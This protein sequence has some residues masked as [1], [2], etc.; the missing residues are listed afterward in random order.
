M[1][2]FWCRQLLGRP[3]AA[4]RFRPHVEALDGRI[5]PTFLP[6]A[7]FAVAG[8]T[9]AVKSADFT[10]DG[11]ADLAVLSSS[12]VAFQ[13]VGTLT[14]LPG[15]GDGTFGAP[16]SS[17]A[18][19]NP[20]SLTIGDDNR[21]GLKDVVVSGYGAVY[22][23][24][25]KGDGSFQPAAYYPV[26]ASP[27]EVT[28]GDLNGDGYPDLVTASPG[29]GGTATVIPN[30]GDGTYAPGHNEATSVGM[31]DV[32]LEDLNHDGK[33]DIV[34]G[35]AGGV[36]VKLGNGDGTFQSQRVFA[37]AGTRRLVVADFNHDGNAD[38]VALAG[39]IFGQGT[40]MPV[41]LGL[42]DGTFQP[43]SAF[44]LSSIPTDVVAA[45]FNADGNLDLVEPMASGYQV[46][47]GRGDGTFYAP[48]GVAGGPGGRAGV[49]D[50]NGDGMADVVSASSALVGGLSTGQVAELV[51]ANDWATMCGATGL[52]V[53]APATAV[54]GQ[55]FSVTVTA[56]DAA[57]NPAPNFQGS[58]ALTLGTGRG[59]QPVS[60]T[61]AAA[62]AGVHTFIGAASLLAAGPQAVVATSP[63]ILN[64]TA[65][66]QVT[67]AA[68][69]R[70]VVGTPL[71]AAA[72][73]SVVV[74]VSALDPYGNVSPGYAGTVRFA[75]SDP[76]AT[77]PATYAFSAADAGVHTFAVSFRSTGAQALTATD[78]LAPA[79][80]GNSPVVNVTPGVAV[81]L[82]VSGGGGFVGS[83]H[84]VTVTARDMFGNI[85]TGY[86]G[87]AH[88]AGSDPATF[89]PADL[90]MTNG[91]AVFS[92]TPMT[93]GSL[94]LTATTASGLNASQTVTVTPG[95]AARLVVT[96]LA[97]GVA[98]TAQPMTVTAYD[99]FGNLSTVYT[100]TVLVGGTDP[101]AA[102]AY[103]FTAADAGVHTFSVALKTAGTQ[104]VTVRDSADATVSATQAGV[105]V[106]PAAAV[107]LN[108]TLLSNAVA[109]TVQTMT[110]CLR[111][112]YGNAATGY[113]GTLHFGS[114]DVLAGLP[115]DTTFT[116]ADAGTKTFTVTL[117]S[118]RGQIVTVGDT[119]NAALAFSQTDIQVSAAAMVGFAFR[120]PSSATAGVAFTV[121]L[122]A[123][124][125]FGNVITGYTGRVHFSGPGGIPADTTF[126]TADA[127]A[128]TF[129]LTL[130][131]T[132]TQTVSVAD[133][134]AGGLR[135]S[136]AISV[137]A[138]GGGG[139][140][141]KP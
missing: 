56:V 128:K 109:G 50:F 136:F 54:A 8:T 106:T 83:A 3:P 21:D 26:G 104:S 127:G 139:G 105:V 15:N 74:S 114:T 55:L 94:T 16:I 20:T 117:K 78:T 13:T 2:R 41:L 76:L 48:V 10:G 97:G 119:A 75:S 52:Q 115:A 140:G 37:A 95:W 141:K 18:G 46:E 123:V 53:V 134:L 90:T 93:L 82:A 86:T 81:S 124:D 137:K 57:G 4:R 91:T 111:D 17:P 59:A 47:L 107:A 84:P 80:T 131:A 63:F 126:T 135:G 101:Q 34:S 43:A 130:T 32:K 77:L 36:G 38:V 64:G 1:F 102:Q 39:T 118:A 40:S 24:H 108:S 5:V 51:N 35:S 138:A 58:V 132:G 92:V 99:A 12:V 49:G 69:T 73:E 22:V 96:P 125:A 14:V 9:V 7:G 65:S 31:L 61:F 89:M 30:N 72:G 44:F 66:V 120:A 33:L 98:G 129:S 6:A 23:L 71:G 87:T 67:P 133:T 112:A 70:L 85:A 103:A 25:G 116:A 79:L 42:G 45:D 62:D 122:S 110:V 11:K 28:E 19:A 60:Y 100:G 88:L 68:A 113:R 29:Y 121:T 27:Y